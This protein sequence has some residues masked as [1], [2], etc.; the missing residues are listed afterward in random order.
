MV[1]SNSSRAV[2]AACFVYTLLDVL[3]MDADDCGGDDA[4]NAS[5]VDH[6]V[7][8]VGI[9]SDADTPYWIVQNSWGEDWGEDGYIYLTYGE[10]TCGIANWAGLVIV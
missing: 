8:L 10:N 2:M 9:N 4:S 1:Q 3:I 7:I 5:N 6:A